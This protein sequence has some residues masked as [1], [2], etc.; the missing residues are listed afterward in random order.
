MIAK[1]RRRRLAPTVKNLGVRRD[2]DSVVLAVS[3]ENLSVGT[4]HKGF[5]VAVLNG[6]QVAVVS[7]RP[8]MLA[9]RLRPDQL[10]RVDNDLKVAL[11]PYAVITLQVSAPAEDAQ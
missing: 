7:A 1:A 5:P 2:G 3:G 6:E 9:L 4:E 11:D 8:H 10:A